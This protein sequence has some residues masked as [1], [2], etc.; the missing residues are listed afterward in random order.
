MPSVR[1]RTHGSRA[2]SIDGIRSFFRSCVDA[3]FRAQGRGHIERIEG[4]E[5][6]SQTR[7]SQERDIAES[8]TLR[9]IKA[10]N[11]AFAPETPAFAYRKIVLTPI[12]RHCRK[13]AQFCY[14]TS[15]T[16][17]YVFQ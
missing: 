4:K 3:R 8:F 9:T 7:L 10:G 17:D 11:R 6:G 14:F 16:W 5:A 2:L 15:F 13:E 1:I 12:F